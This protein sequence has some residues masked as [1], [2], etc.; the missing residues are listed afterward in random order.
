MDPNANLDEIRRIIDNNEKGGTDDLLRLA[1]LVQTLDE[2]L[3][4]AA[5]CQRTGRASRR[6]WVRKL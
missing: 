4:C 2:W 3:V 5:S 6:P 1:E